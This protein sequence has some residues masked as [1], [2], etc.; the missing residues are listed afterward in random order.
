MPKSPEKMKAVKDR[1]F[2]AAMELFEERGYE[3]TAV[4]DITQKAGVSKGTFF[5]HFASKD[6]V[7]S[8]IGRIFTEYMQDIVEAGLAENRST[9][10]ILLDCIN[11]ADEWCEE[12]KTIIRQVLFSGMHQMSIGSRTT[13]N[14]VVMAEMLI[15]ILKIGQQKGEISSDISAEDA[16]TMLVGM[17]FTVMYDWIND[18]GAWSMKDKMT[19]CLEIVFRGIAQ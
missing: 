12:N 3:N 15:R 16:A 6:A 4:A 13:N 8:A 17:Y 9:R 1:L 10:K 7:F 14:R 18:N 19:R 2:K 11:M 5:T